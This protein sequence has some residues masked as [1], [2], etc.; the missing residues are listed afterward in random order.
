MANSK[1]IHCRD[2]H[3]VRV[4]NIYIHAEMDL[5]ALITKLK[6]KNKPG[7]PWLI[8]KFHSLVCS[9]SMPTTAQPRH[10]ASAP[11]PPP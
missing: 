5:S 6:G 7:S 3:L 10:H 2:P 11:P 1:F 4:K 8:F 9:D